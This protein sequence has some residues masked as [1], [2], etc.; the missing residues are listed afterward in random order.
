MQKLNQHTITG[1]QISNQHTITGHQ[2]SKDNYKLCFLIF[3]VKTYYLV[4]KRTALIKL[5]NKDYHNLVQKCFA[6]P[7][8]QNKLTSAYNCEYFLIYQ[9]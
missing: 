2:I 8:C 5:L 3:S 1:H 9:F 6:Y 4:L 7:I